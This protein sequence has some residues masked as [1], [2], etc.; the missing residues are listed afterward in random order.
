MC[1]QSL[2]F[3]DA[4]LKDDYGPGLK[5][6]LNNSN[7]V[8][9]EVSRN[10]EDIQGR[11]AVWSLHSGRSTSTGAAGEL[12]PLPVADRQRFTQLRDDLAYLYHTIKVSGPSIHLT[13]GDSGAFTRALEAEIDGAEKD[14]KNDCARQAFGDGVDIGGTVYAGSLGE[15]TV[16]AGNVLTMGNLTR[17]EMLP[18]FVNEKV[19]VIDAATGASRGT[20]T[21][22]AIDKAAGTVTVAAAPGGTVATDLLARAGA[23]GEEMNGLRFLISDTSVYAGVDPATVPSWAALVVGSTGAG[24]EIDEVLLDEAVESVET[25]GN[26]DTPSLY[27]FNHLQRRKQASLLQTQKRWDGKEVTLKAGWRGLNIAQGTLVADRFC[28]LNDGFGITP[29]HLQR[30]VGLDFTWDTDDKGG[31]LYKALDGSD[32]VEARYKSYQNL[33]ATTRNAHVRILVADPTFT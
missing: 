11:Q 30:F 15:I 33:E 21:I 31:V 1:P 6:A 12:A 13:Q 14:L 4:A 2:A 9:T 24:N 19:D 27:I 16:V 28:P 18:F 29:K 7:P 22:T 17:P 23:F 32:A 10:D 26:G 5:E 8:W 25:E 20:T 3:F